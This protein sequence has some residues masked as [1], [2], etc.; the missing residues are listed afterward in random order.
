MPTLTLEISEELLAALQL[1][2]RERGMTSEEVAVEILESALLLT[3]DP[4]DMAKRW[5]E[6]WRGRLKGREDVTGADPRVQYLL[7]S[8][9][10]D[11]WGPLST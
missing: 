4:S 8:T 3:A 1:A 2:S 11:V 10:D 6:K 5:V 9:C 7:R